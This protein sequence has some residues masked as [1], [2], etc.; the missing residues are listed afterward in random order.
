MS[1][2]QD[3]LNPF[4]ILFSF[5]GR[6]G[7]LDFFLYSLLPVGVSLW[8]SILIFLSWFDHSPLF[9]DRIAFY[10]FLMI[11][12]VSF[13]I[14]VAVQVKRWHDIDRSGWWIL[15]NT[16]P[17]AYIL[18]F[19]LLLTAEG[20]DGPNR[21]GPD[22]EWKYDDE[23]DENTE[24][25][26]EAG[27]DVLYPS[28]EGSDEPSV[29][30]VLVGLGEDSVPI[31]LTPGA[32]VT[33]GRSHRATIYLPDRYVSGMHLSL[34]LDRNG[35]VVVRDLGSTN[36]TFIQG[37]RLQPNRKYLLREGEQLSIGSKKSVYFLQKGRG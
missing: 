18:L 29:S 9:T 25:E 13:W 7:R 27:D 28:R 5:K 11:F 33:V 14:I 20:T 17:Y 30:R 16:I 31:V 2:C 15:L 21:F 37:R 36:G 19:F 34:Y 23:C 6:I 4:E 1:H 35:E 12:F 8:G 10:S 26:D 32:E 24:D 3:R 22:S